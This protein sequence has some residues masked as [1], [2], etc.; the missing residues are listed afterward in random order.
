MAVREL[1]E[2]RPVSHEWKLC[3][4]V[5]VNLKWHCETTDFSYFEFCGEFTTLK[6]KSTVPTF[7]LLSDEL[8]AN[9]DN[10]KESFK[11]RT[12]KYDNV[13]IV[14][15][16]QVTGPMC[17]GRTLKP[18]II[19]SDNCFQSASD[20]PDM[21]V[22]TMPPRT[23]YESL[24]K[25]IE[26]TKK[27]PAAGQRNKKLPTGKNK[28][29]KRKRIKNNE[30]PN[31]ARLPKQ[32]INNLER[33][34]LGVVFQDTALLRKQ[35]KQEYFAFPLLT[36]PGKFAFVRKKT[37]ERLL[38]AWDG[39]YTPAEYDAEIVKEAGI[40]QSYTAV[41]AGKQSHNYK[42]TRITLLTK[43]PDRGDANWSVSLQCS[44]MFWKEKKIVIYLLLT[45]LEIFLTSS[46]AGWH[47][48]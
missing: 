34:L 18:S 41:D 19:G 44:S 39:K 20:G 42:G 15:L 24:Y 35:D 22:P 31:F 33:E 11:Y 27:L 47:C 30:A 36:K 17:G 29:G 23:E 4:G 16:N 10:V 6:D 45:R 32:H 46:T 7:S 2:G 5:H 38:N 13:E 40:V 21:L 25:T 28:G 3:F 8:A 43:P 14:Y 12:S 26:D 48:I 1:H 9:W 37:A